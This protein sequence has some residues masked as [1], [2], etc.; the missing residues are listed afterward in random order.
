MNIGGGDIIENRLKTIRYNV[1]VVQIKSIKTKT[2][3]TLVKL[4]GLMVKF[5]FIKTSNTKTVF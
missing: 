1:L 4:Q 2:G 3:D 5:S